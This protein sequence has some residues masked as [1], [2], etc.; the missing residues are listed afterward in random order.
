MQQKGAEEAEAQEKN[1][2]LIMTEKDTQRNSDANEQR[3]SS[4]EQRGALGG[5]VPVAEGMP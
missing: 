4:S 1:A 2:A 3:K 5:F